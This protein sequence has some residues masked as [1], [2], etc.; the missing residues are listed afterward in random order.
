[1][2]CSALKLDKHIKRINQWAASDYT[3]LNKQKQP[4]T[5]T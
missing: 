1:M 4:L 5:N 3:L 2:L